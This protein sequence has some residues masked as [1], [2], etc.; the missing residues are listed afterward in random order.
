M[1]NSP[2]RGVALV[3]ILVSDYWKEK[4]IKGKET[5]VE[6]NKLGIID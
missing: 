1:K 5:K 4:H 3:L 6:I 2:G